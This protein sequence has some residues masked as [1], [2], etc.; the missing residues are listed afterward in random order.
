MQHIT[1]VLKDGV[2]VADV[3]ANLKLR[4][5]EFQQGMTFRQR[6]EKI[7]RQFPDIYAAQV[8]NAEN[9]LKGMTLLPGCPTLHFIGNP[10][11]WHE[12]LF[13]DAEYTYQLNRMD[14]W[15]VM[16]EAYSLTGDKRFANKV[17]EE[18]YHWIEDCPR[19][20][21]YNSDGEL[22]KDNFGGCGCNQGIWR[23]LEIGIRM[24]RTWP[25]II[26]HLID[27]D[28]IDEA[29]L[30]TYL[31][32]VYQHAQVLYLVAP[33]FW[34]KAD[35]NHYLMEN[36]GLLYLSCMFP[37]F[38]DAQLWRCHALHE[39]E[40]SINAQVTSGGGQIEGCASYHNG[41][42]YW[43]VLP[44]LLSK[45][46]GFDIS[47][48]YKERLKLM[49]EYSLF[50]TRPTGS[51]CPWGDSNTYTGT[52]SWG[53]LCHYIAFDDT[54][55]MQYA[56]CFYSYEDLTRA[57]SKYIWEISDL[58]DLQRAL[59]KSREAGTLPSIPVFSWQK[60]LKQVFLRT[61]WSQNALSLMFACRTPIQNQHAHMDPAG[62]DFTAYGKPLLVDPGIYCYRDDENR[63][64]FKSVHWHNCLTLNHQDPWR[65]ISSWSYGEQQPG[66][67]LHAEENG[68]LMYAV[69]EHRN[70]QPAVHKR[71]AA[72]VDKH[73]L[74]ILDLLEQTEEDS[75]V[76]IN[77]HINSPTVAADS[78]KSCVCS[79]SADAN[80]GV[81]T[82]D[83]LKPALVP[84]K[85]S[86]RCDVWHDTIIARF[87]AEHLSAGRHGFVSIAC[88]APAGQTVPTVSGIKKEFTA[89]GRF[90]VSF[91]VM[92]KRYE[93]ALS[94]KRLDL[95]V[96]DVNGCL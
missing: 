53:A 1:E 50:M 24:Y 16:L 75:S 44:L 54:R 88:P 67:I 30:E 85:C 13:N 12:N 68:R 22:L 51:N 11:K 47:D 49:A 26:H 23:S 91:S 82:D 4:E 43:F 83:G 45:K 35:H 57:A 5:K 17:M 29:F 70:Y 69:A 18:F 74:V 33:I 90:L 55:Y 15:R 37:E 73:F 95:S 94:G 20:P 28:Y 9:C 86:N 14:H 6:G 72:L 8:E 79:I 71:A 32:S 61:D 62:F 76:Q 89:D 87:E 63:R 48:S 66:E 84:A 52:L 58:D 40:R 34:P 93:L 38:K 46:Y 21:L 31:T 36:N 10:V 60:E 77:F 27:S 42:I 25:H 92:E 41:C 59:E 56:R 7:R 65:Y 96:N 39:M 81:F 19:Q 64:K 78:A 2:T 80:I 3:L